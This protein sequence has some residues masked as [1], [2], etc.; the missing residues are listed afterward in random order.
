[1]RWIDLSPEDFRR[2]VAETSL[3]V[4][5]IGS[6]ERHG[7]HG[8]FG[9]DG[10]IAETLAVKAAE[11]EPSVVFPVWWF[12]QV[13]EASCFEGSIN[14]PPEMLITMLRQLLNQIAKNGFKKICIL[15]GHGGNNN[16][17]QFFDMSLLDEPRDYTLYMINTGSGLTDEEKERVAE[18]WKTEP[19]HG[20]ESETSMSMSCLPGRVKLENQPY[21]E[22]IEP[23]NRMSHLKG[24][25]SGLWWYADYPENVTGCPSLASEEKGKKALAIEAP[26]IA[27]LLKT[28]K[29]DKVLPH[30]QKEFLERTHLGN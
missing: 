30:L 18:I 22:P 24:V 28:I 1:M 15:N 6:L 17:L 20:A 2:A 19:N 16:W 12:G 13:H 10:I 4:L 8:Y 27:R 23:L 7:E 26:A 21:P 3:C 29:E 14:F 5:P 25:Y 9:T 11:M